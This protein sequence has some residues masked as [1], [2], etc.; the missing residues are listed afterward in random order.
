MGRAWPS[1]PSGSCHRKS[2]K[3][4]VVV[5]EADASSFII[6]YYQKGRSISVK[7]YGRSSLVSDTVMDKFEQR[8]RAVGLSEDVTYHFPTYGGW[9][10]VLR[11]TH[12]GSVPMLRSPQGQRC[13]DGTVPCNVLGVQGLEHARSQT[14]GSLPNS[15]LLQGFVTLQMSFTSSMVSW[16]CGVMHWVHLCA[17]LGPT[18]GTSR[19]SLSWQ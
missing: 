12:V 16:G 4:D 2:S 6:L 5:G 1:A 13:K 14:R 7:L 11:E 18:L 8:I 19:V 9:H 15:C 10:T 17:R 3:V